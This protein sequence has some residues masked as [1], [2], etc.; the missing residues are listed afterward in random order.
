MTAIADTSFVLAVLNRNEKSHAQCVEVYKQETEIFLPQTALNEIAYMISR[1]G[2]NSAL[3][4]FLER[5]PL[6]KYQLVSLEFVDYQRITELLYQYADSRIDFV[7][8]SL[9]AIAERMDID[10][11]LTLDHRDFRIVRPRHCDYLTLSPAQRSQG[12]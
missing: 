6:M 10:H 4:Q 7:D 5:L 1:S 3:A 12:G 11:I 9:V 8:L 2:G